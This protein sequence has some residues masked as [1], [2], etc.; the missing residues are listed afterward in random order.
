MK[1]YFPVEEKKNNL[2]LNV[3]LLFMPDTQADG[4]SNLPHAIFYSEE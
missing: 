3:K 1:Y 4:N 2:I